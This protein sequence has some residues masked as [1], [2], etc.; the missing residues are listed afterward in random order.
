MEIM[1][2]PQDSDQESIPHEEKQ[3]LLTHFSEGIRRGYSK[4][5]LISTYLQTG[6]TEE[7]LRKA[8]IYDYAVPEEELQTLKKEYYAVVQDD[9]QKSLMVNASSKKEGEGEREGYLDNGFPG[10]P[11]RK[12]GKDVNNEKQVQELSKNK[13]LNEHLKKLLSDVQSHELRLREKEEEATELRKKLEHG[14]TIIR[15]KEEE[16]QKQTSL[17]SEKEHKI[18]ELEKQIHNV[19][20]ALAGKALALEEKEQVIQ[21]I[22]HTGSVKKQDL[23]AKEGEID[24]LKEELA[25]KKAELLEKDKKLLGIQQGLEEEKRN[26]G[27]HTSLELKRLKAEFDNV[28]REREDARAQNKLLEEQ[29]QELTKKEG[30]LKKQEELVEL[31]NKLIENKERELEKKEKILRTIGDEKEYQKFIEKTRMI[32]ELKDKIDDL[33]LKKEKEGGKLDMIR[34]FGDSLGVRINDLNEKLG[35]LRSTV[36]ARERMV[37]KIEKDFKNI[38]DQITDVNPAG[39]K[40]EFEK[41]DTSLVHLEA[42]TEL[43]KSILENLKEE[44]KRYREHLAKIKNYD[45]LLRDIDRIDKKIKE[46]T[47]IHKNVLQLSNRIEVISANVTQSIKHFAGHES[48]ISSVEEILKDLNKTMVKQDIEM[49]KFANQEDVQKAIMESEKRIHDRMKAVDKLLSEAKDTLFKA[50]MKR[51]AGA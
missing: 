39:I 41:R 46:A 48:R 5:R 33:V 6:W 44:I 32:S 26:F 31:N 49:S 16:L 15:K 8:G 28:T 37:E 10:A 17:A 27:I 24:R 19:S 42:T 3:E 34:E 21:K 13:A 25:A 18:A 2:T 14:I 38:Q 51:F 12:K 20:Q 35:E 50:E 45:Q 22:E 23:I 7:D 4:E 9:A 30:E 29:I 43:N 11:Q 47:I 40:N 36:M 1:K